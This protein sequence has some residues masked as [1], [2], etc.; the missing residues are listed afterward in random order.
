MPA[1][2]QQGFSVREPMWHGLGEVLDEY[3]GR[4]EA[5]V[6]AG[7]DFTVVERPFLVPTTSPLSEED[8][9]PDRYLFDGSDYFPADLADGWK[10]LIKMSDR[11]EEEP[12][13]GQLLHVAKESYGVVQNSVGWDIVDAMIGVEGVRY[14]T[15]ILIGETGAVCAVLAWLDEPVQ[16]P[17]D[18]SEIFPWLNVSWSHDG[19]SAVSCR[20]TSI[21]TVCWNTQSAAEALGKRTDTEFTFRHSKN[22]MARIEDAKMAIRGVRAAHEEYVELARELAEIEVTEKQRELFVSEFIPMPP[23]A[24]ISERV[25]GNVEG[26]RAELRSLFASKTVPEA[27]ELTAYGLH[28]AGGEYLDHIRGYRN[29]STRFNRS[30]LRREPAKAK[31]TKLI[32]EVANA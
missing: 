13:H 7:H 22:V 27:H 15:G 1:Y 23:E 20:P 32:R 6:R 2:F 18:D 24:L 17:G 28:L 14:E 4:E 29:E 9:L 19:S 11:G 31:M 10:A 25:K 12:T 21:R 26:A 30:I 5:I 16:I 8:D 3:P